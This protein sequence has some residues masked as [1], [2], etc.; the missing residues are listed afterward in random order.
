MEEVLRAMSVTWIK[1][2]DNYRVG[3]LVKELR[4]ARLTREKGL[5]VIL[6]DGECQ[7]ARQRRIKPAMAA[8]VAAGKRVMRRRFWVDEESCTGDPSCIRL[9]GCPSLTIKQ[10]R[11]IAWWRVSERQLAYGRC[12]VILGARNGA[13]AGGGPTIRC[14]GR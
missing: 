5:K 14:P 7:L 4:E 8:A 3:T 11:L 13:V 1:R 6:A 10:W 2:V 12:R 9:S